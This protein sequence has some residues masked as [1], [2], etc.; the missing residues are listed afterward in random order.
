MF[1]TDVANAR[2]LKVQDHTKFADAHIF[3]SSQAK[4]VGLVDEVSTLT[5]AQNRVIELSGVTNPSW[6]KEDKFDK[7]LD[8]IIQETVS[9]FSVLFEGGLKAY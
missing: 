3:T 1:I 7:F 5:F 8:R 6:K 4:E 2:G 9:N